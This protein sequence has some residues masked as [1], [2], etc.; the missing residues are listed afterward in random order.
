MCRLICALTCSVLPRL[1]LSCWDREPASALNRPETSR[2]AGRTDRMRH[3]LRYRAR[4]Q[5]WVR[6]ARGGG[7]PPRNPARGGGGVHFRMRCRR[8]STQPVAELG[9]TC[10]VLCALAES[11]AIRQGTMPPLDNRLPQSRKACLEAPPKQRPHSSRQC[12]GGGRRA[13]QVNSVSAKLL[14]ICCAD[15]MCGT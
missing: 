2:L 12:S 10:S 6:P 5:K 1:G 7:R 8:F 4:V 9:L 15:S 13:G 14:G 11:R 3:M